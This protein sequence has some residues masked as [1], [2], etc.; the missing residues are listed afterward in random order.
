MVQL[1]KASGHNIVMVMKAGLLHTQQEKQELECIDGENGFRNSQTQST[2]EI[3]ADEESCDSLDCL[4]DSSTTSLE[5]LQRASL[6]PGSD[7]DISSP[8]SI[9]DAHKNLQRALS[10][11]LIDGERSKS[12]AGAVGGVRRLSDS[13]ELEETDLGDP[14]KRKRELPWQPVMGVYCPVLYSMYF[15][16]IASLSRGSVLRGSAAETN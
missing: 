3:T 10:N 4:A 6:S 8:G 13:A 1:L 16:L 14:L 2:N 5:R 9:P 12:T 15:P 7:S 11:P